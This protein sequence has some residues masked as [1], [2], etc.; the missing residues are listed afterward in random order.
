M[1]PATLDQYRI[2][3]KAIG[4]GLLVGVAVRVAGEGMDMVVGVISPVL[5]LVRC[6]LG[7]LWTVVSF[8]SVDEGLSFFQVLS[9]LNL[10]HLDI[11]VNF[12]T[13][14]LNATGC[15]TASTSASVPGTVSAGSPG[16]TRNTYQ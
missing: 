11:P 10:A 12:L 14:T 15:S 5:S 4:I 16:K 9:R 3:W 13:A 2:R 1:A 7:N 8:I 6:L